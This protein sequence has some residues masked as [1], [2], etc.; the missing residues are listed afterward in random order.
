[1]TIQFLNFEQKPTSILKEVIQ[2]L[3]LAELQKLPQ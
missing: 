2:T 3:L 1:M